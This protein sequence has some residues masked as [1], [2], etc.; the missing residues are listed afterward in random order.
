MKQVDCARDVAKRGSAPLIQRNKKYSNL[1]LSQSPTPTHTHA[2]LRN[3][4]WCTHAGTHTTAPQLPV[5]VCTCYN[6]CLG[7]CVASHNQQKVPNFKANAH[8][9]EFDS[10]LQR[11]KTEKQH[12]F[13][14]S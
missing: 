2:P 6:Y 12:F 1:V 14:H 4:M 10:C 11:K 8:L 13:F 3:E 7:S 5:F 9:R